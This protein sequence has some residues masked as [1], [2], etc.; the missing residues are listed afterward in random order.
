LVW[1]ERSFWG[2]RMGW[3]GEWFGERDGM[4]GGMVWEEYRLGGRSV[5]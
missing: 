2:R 4:G 5:A 1:G 3:E